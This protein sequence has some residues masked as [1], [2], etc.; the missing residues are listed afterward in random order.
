MA[1]NS[2]IEKLDR[3]L[4][5]PIVSERQVVYIL[6]EIRKLL[7]LS[8]SDADFRSLRFHCDWAVHIKLDRAGARLVLQEFDEHQCRIED[9]KVAGK[10]EEVPEDVESLDKL[11]K[12]VE[13]RAF[14]EELLMFLQQNG[15]PADQVE[16][17]GMWVEFLRH[18]LNVIEDSPL[19]CSSPGFTHVR[20]VVVRVC[21][22]LDGSAAAKLGIS[23]MVEW[24]WKALLSGREM[25]AV[26]CF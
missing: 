13:L 19:V 16:D 15:L 3:E 21:D 18:Y 11:M 14:R 24:R 23:V 1:R 22:F 10:A 25:K 17:G 20:E 8:G 9:S 26:L 4:R 7:S 5:E 2:I 6:V 12:I